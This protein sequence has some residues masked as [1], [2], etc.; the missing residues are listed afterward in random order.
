MAADKNRQAE[1]ID[2]RAFQ[3]GLVSSWLFAAAPSAFA[4]TPGPSRLGVYRK[5][6][7]GVDGSDAVWWCSGVL[8]G[9]RSNGHAWILLRVEGLNFLYFDDLGD[10]ALRQTMQEAAIWSGPEGGP[11][12][13]D[14]TNPL[15]GLPC[16]PPH[17]ARTQVIDFSP[18]GGARRPAAAGPELVKYA[19]GVAAPEILGDTIWQGMALVTKSLTGERNPAEDPLT[20]P[21]P[22]RSQ[23]HTLTLQSEVRFVM[24]TRRGFTPATMNL[25]SLDS[26]PPWMRMGPTDGQVMLQVHGKKLESVEQAPERF[27][28]DL[29]VHH[30]GWIE[31][32]GR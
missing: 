28:A 1:G 32:R 3:K 12:I 4:A 21:G 22:V 6:R 16:K 24:S 18:T 26:W 17:F 8:W 5:I 20:D 13:E 2:R 29:S 25:Q 10:G 15:N 27:R 19:G 9:K 11:P 30:P 31:R 14:W 23:T 7:G